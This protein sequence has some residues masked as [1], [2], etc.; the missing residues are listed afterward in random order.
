QDAIRTLPF[1]DSHA[2]VVQSW[3]RIAAKGEVTYYQELNGPQS[4]VLERFPEVSVW[5]QTRL[6]EQ[7]LGVLDAGLVDFQRSR[8][9]DGLRLDVA[10]G[11][12]L[13]LPLGKF[14]FGALHASVRETA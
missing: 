11:A 5:G 13:P 7:A 1:T 6:G 4:R 8:D 12:L 2:G 14:A 10:P 3:E 9:V